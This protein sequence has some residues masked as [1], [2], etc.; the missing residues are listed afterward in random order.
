MGLLDDEWEEAKPFVAPERG[1]GRKYENQTV[2]SQHER[3]AQLN[4]LQAEEM[5]AR[6]WEEET[7]NFDGEFTLPND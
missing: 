1:K 3:D 4:N 6:E 5:D 2:L 7:M